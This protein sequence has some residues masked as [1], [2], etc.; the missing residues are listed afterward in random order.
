[1][2][3]SHLVHRADNIQA[4]AADA[5]ICA[6]GSSRSRSS[7]SAPSLDTDPKVASAA[8]GWE[9]QREACGCDGGPNCGLLG[10]LCIQTATIRRFSPSSCV[11]RK[12]GHFAGTWTEK[13]GYS[14][15]VYL[16]LDQVPRLFPYWVRN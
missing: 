1:V 14:C 15:V 4:M 9:E 5:V 8:V 12:P 13:R 11:S 2:G 7:P 10:C 3:E 16:R 6:R